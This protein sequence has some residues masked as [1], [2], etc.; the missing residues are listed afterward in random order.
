LVATH[1]HFTPWLSAEL[2]TAWNCRTVAGFSP[3]LESDR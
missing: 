1:A 2:I 3:P